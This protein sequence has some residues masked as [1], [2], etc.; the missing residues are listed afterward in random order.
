[1]KVLNQQ[2][3]TQW[4]ERRGHVEDPHLNVDWVNALPENYFHMM[5][6]APIAYGSIESFTDQYLNEIVTDGD[7]LLQIVEWDV[8]C[9][10]RGF[11]IKSLLPTFD[12]TVPY[13]K[14]GGFLFK[15]SE[16]KNAIAIFSLTTSFMWKSYLYGEFDQAALYNWEGEIFDCWTSSSVKHQAVDRLFLQFNLLPV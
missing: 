10:P 9:E 16:W 14:M 4:L 6:R 2:E 5:R 7:L 13:R 3:T 1:M 11:I 12:E 8:W 15:K